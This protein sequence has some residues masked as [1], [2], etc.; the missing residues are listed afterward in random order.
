[1]TKTVKDAKEQGVYSMVKEMSDYAEKL[2]LSDL[3]DVQDGIDVSGY[4]FGDWHKPMIPILKEIKDAYSYF[5]HG[6]MSEDFEGRFYN[7]LKAARWCLDKKLYQQFLT[8]LQEGIQSFSLGLISRNAGK[9]VDVRHEIS[10]YLSKKYNR[11][12]G[13]QNIVSELEKKEPAFVELIGILGGEAKPYCDKFRA[14]S[15]WRNCINHAW[16]NGESVNV[17]KFKP[18]LEYYESFLSDRKWGRAKPV[19]R[20]SVF[21]NLSN[22]PSNLWGPAQSHA[23]GAYGRIVDV[24]FPS[25]SPE[26]TAEDVRA[27]AE[28]YLAKVLEYSRDADVTVH[29]MG[30][31][32]FSFFLVRMLQEY[33]IV[34]V[35]SCS[36]RIVREENGEKISRFEFVRFR[37]Y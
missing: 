37:N 10:T 24:P 30:E 6:I 26:M 17:K 2:R 21:L 19:S 3:K 16:M 36:D 8:V 23:A 4:E 29:I 7:T 14:L 35:A 11:H 5:R 28:E 20:P 1:M 22:H 32:T 27:L 34:C 9:I 33:G 13:A 31:L 25:V 12:A 18:I 15:D